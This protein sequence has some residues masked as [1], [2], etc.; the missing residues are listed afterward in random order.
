MAYFEYTGS[1]RTL[2]STVTFDRI[3][4]YL[5]EIETLLVMD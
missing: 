4:T 5:D 3:R 2:T 1:E